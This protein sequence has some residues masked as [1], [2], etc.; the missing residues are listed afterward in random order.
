MEQAA[1]REVSYADFLT[2]L[3][4]VEVISNTQKHQMHTGR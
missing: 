2:E 4:A 3:R 1:K